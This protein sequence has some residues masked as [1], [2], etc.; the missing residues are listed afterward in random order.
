[1]WWA[2]MCPTMWKVCKWLW[3]DVAITEDSA[4]LIVWKVGKWLW[5]DVAITEDSAFLTVWKVGKW[6]W[7]DVAIT[8][9]SAFLGYRAMSVGIWFPT[10]WR[11]ARSGT[12]CPVTQQRIPKEQKHQPHQCNVKMCVVT[13]IFKLLFNASYFLGSS[14]TVRAGVQQ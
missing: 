10:L 1:M 13:A 9:D 6:L 2:G 14:V 12:E 5:K 8:E 4:F 11:I 7:K 3:K